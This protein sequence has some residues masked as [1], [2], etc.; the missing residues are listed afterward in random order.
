MTGAEGPVLSLG[1]KLATAA[2]KRFF[3]S[4]EFDRLC[5]RLAE[6]FGELT[7]YVAAD[8]AAWASDDAFAAALG[9]VHLPSA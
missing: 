2:G 3:K 7:S 9:P 1:L 5:G 8:Y 6:R 4:T